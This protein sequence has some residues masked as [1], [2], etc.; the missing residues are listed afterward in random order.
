MRSI[1]ASI[2]F[3]IAALASGCGETDSAAPSVANAAPTPANASTIKPAAVVNPDTSVTVT[4]PIIVEHQVDLAAQRDGVLQKIFFD[5]PARVKA[6]T[7]LAELDDRQIAAN[8]EAARAKSRSISADIKNWEAEAQVLKAD[9]VRAQKLSKLG[10]ISEEQLEHAKYK[11]E[12]DEWDIKRVT[13]TLNTAHE[14]E[15]SLELELEKTKIIAPFDGVIARRYVREGQNVVKG[16]RLFWVTAEGPLMMRFTLPEK[17]FSLLH[18][19]ESLVVSSE[20]A[21]GERH[22]AR[23]REISPVIDP[24]SGTFEVLV[25]LIGDRRSLRPGM[26]AHVILDSQ[27]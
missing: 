12:S 22:M 18:R 3:A 2:V 9:Y 6:G 13:E 19:G 27:R 11:A 1:I 5:A 24:S 26:A 8:L 21:P 15:H 23:V 7:L 20:D 16:D 4:G 25:E 17:E 10:L 14:E